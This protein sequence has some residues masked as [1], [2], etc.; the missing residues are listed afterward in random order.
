ESMSAVEGQRM[1]PSISL[2]LANAYSF[3]RRDGTHYDIDKA[4]RTLI[5]GLEVETTSG[6]LNNL[7]NALRR[8]YHAGTHDTYLLERSANISEYSIT[9]ID[10]H[11]QPYAYVRRAGNLANTYELMGRQDDALRIHRRLVALAP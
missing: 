6:L 3:R 1:M 8:K 10:P 11:T 5:D 4:I 9:L 2:N 7:A